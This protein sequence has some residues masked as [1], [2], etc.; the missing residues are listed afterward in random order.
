LAYFVQR[1][2]LKKGALLKQ[3]KKHINS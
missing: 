2:K 3:K 1:D